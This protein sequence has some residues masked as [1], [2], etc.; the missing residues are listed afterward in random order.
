MTEVRCYM[1]DISGGMARQMS[2]MLLGRQINAIWHTAVVAFGREYFFDGGVGIEAGVPART[3]FGTP[4]SMVAIGTTTKTREAFEEHNRGLM[5]TRFGPTQYHVLQNNCNH[6]TDVALQF[7]SGVGAPPEVMEQVDVFLSTP[8]GRQLQPMIENMMGGFAAPP[9]QQ[10]QQA[11]VADT[12]PPPAVAACITELVEEFDG[13]VE[14]LQTLAKVFSNLVAHPTEVRYRTLKLTNKEVAR[15]VGR[16]AAAMSVLTRSG[17]VEKDGVMTFEPVAPPSRALV[18][19]LAAAVEEAKGIAEAIRLSGGG[20]GVEEAAPTEAAAPPQTA[21]WTRWTGEAPAGAVACGRE[22]GAGGQA[23]YV[24]RSVELGEAGKCGAHLGASVAVVSAENREVAR[25]GQVLVVPEGAAAATWQKVASASPLLSGAA[26][27]RYV[28]VGTW[29]GGACFAAR[30]AHEGGVHPGF[31]GGNTGGCVIPFGGEG[32]CVPEYEVLCCAGGVRDEAE[33]ASEAVPRQTGLIDF[34]ELVAF[35]KAAVHEAV[36]ARALRAGRNFRYNKTSGTQLM[37]CH[38]MGGNY[39]DADANPFGSAAGRDDFYR[40]RAWD[41]T[42]LFV[43]FSHQFISVP[44]VGWVRAAHRHGVPCLGTVIVEG[45]GG[46]ENLGRMLRDVDSVLLCV[47]KLVEIQEQHGFDGWFINVEVGMPA[48]VVPHFVMFLQCLKDA[49]HSFDADSIVLN[50]DSVVQNGQV[51]FQNRLSDGNKQFFDACDGVFTNYW[52][53]AECPAHSAALADT[54]TKDVWHGID[55]FGRNTFGGGGLDCCKA[56]DVIAK[57]K[58]SAALFATCWPWNGCQE[59]RTQFESN[60]DAFWGRIRPF[61][62]AEAVVTAA[63]FCTTFS[64]GCG[65]ALYANGVKVAGKWFNLSDTAPLPVL[66]LAEAGKEPSASNLRSALCTTEGY[67]G[68]SCLELSFPAAQKMCVAHLFKL[69]SLSANG[70]LSFELV[71]KGTH[72]GLLLMGESEGKAVTLVLHPTSDAAHTDTDA[73]YNAN[74]TDTDL[75]SSWTRRVWNMPERCLEAHPRLVLASVSLVLVASADAAAA[76]GRATGHVGMFAVGRGA[77][78]VVSPLELA[79]AL[80]VTD[81][82]VR[83]DLNS[84]K[85]GALRVQHADVFQGA[86]WLGRTHG[87]CFVAAK[88]KGMQVCTMPRV[89]VR[90]P[91]FLFPTVCQGA[92]AGFCRAAAEAEDGVFVTLTSSSS[93]LTPYEKR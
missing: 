33:G 77:R 39:S 85:T 5:Q 35:E 9:Q 23:L 78:G 1:Y 25:R 17:F 62:K 64:T 15:R 89:S 60:D 68:C 34:G 12:P 18:S 51:R 7:L 87:G 6:Y 29:R 69:E 16:H 58:T 40:L 61:Y 38:D 52:W 91:F 83:V 65:S 32:K 13:G 41:V 31:C 21:F 81:S 92:R 88:P 43:Y 46:A 73:C 42:D 66:P 2:G 11:A 22:G 4:L 50:Y 28:R 30:A 19:A 86:T 8:M 26:A 56:L 53:T 47:R 44:T 90:L 74:S 82:T 59:D 71:T 57:A 14:A 72:V 36:S 70:G 20:G 93:T 49:C 48:S 75:A 76:G 3:R 10:Q 55:C 67:E 84:A 80:K 63:P 45:A 27:A 79:P 54:R 37:V 24:G